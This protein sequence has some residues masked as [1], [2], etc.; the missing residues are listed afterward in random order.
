MAASRNRKPAATKASRKPVAL[1]RKRRAAARKGWE[2][3]QANAIKA[4]RSAAARKGWAT[5]AATKIRDHARERDR[6][7]PLEKASRA[8]D[9]YTRKHRKTDPD[10]RDDIKVFFLPTNNKQ[11]KMR[12]SVKSWR[13][14]M[15]EEKYRDAVGD[16]LMSGRFVLGLQAENGD[17]EEEIE[18]LI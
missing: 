8:A 6:N 2:T 9:R 17:I 3:R 10:I 14:F 16:V 7:N 4:A 5:R 15:R 1:A 11:G 18:E 13:K 12:W